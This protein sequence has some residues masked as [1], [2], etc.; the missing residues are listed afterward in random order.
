MISDALLKL[1]LKIQDLF[2][3]EDGQ[4]LVEYA[5]VVALIAFGAVT[6]MK[7]LSTEI[8]TAFN[9]ISSNLG[10]SL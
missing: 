2:T 1:Q 9:S 3:R 5:L 8:K 7:G 6:A 4:D 10:T